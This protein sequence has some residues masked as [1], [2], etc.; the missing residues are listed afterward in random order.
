[1]ETGQIVAAR[2]NAV[3]AP[4]NAHITCLSCGAA[5]PVQVIQDHTEEFLEDMNCKVLAPQLKALG[6]IPFITEDDVLQSKNKEEANAHLLQY[7]KEDA[8]EESVMEVFRIASQEPGYRRMNTFAASVLMKLQ[9]GLYWC[10][11]T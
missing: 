10:A 4:T 1:M 2:M 7:L 5:T 11:H 9:R 3:V 6:L 8:D